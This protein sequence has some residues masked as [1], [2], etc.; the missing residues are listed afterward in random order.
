MNNQH[1]S[2]KQIEAWWENLSKE[3]RQ[4]G[5]GCIID[6][7]FSHARMMLCVLQDDGT[8]KE[9][10]TYAYDDES[11]LKMLDLIRSKGI[12]TPPLE[13]FLADTNE[14]P[15]A[16]P[17]PEKSFWKNVGLVCG[18]IATGLL[19]YRLIN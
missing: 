9:F 16:E 11:L 7:S 1:I 10:M 5:S 13:T 8:I 3:E 6:I 15:V 2:A 18:G 4:L 19:A 14:Q 12:D 17:L